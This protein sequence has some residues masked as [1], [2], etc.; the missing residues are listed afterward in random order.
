MALN[1]NNRKL[2]GSGTTQ[3]S[4]TRVVVLAD[5]KFLPRGV[6]IDG[7]NSRDPLNT[8]DVD[9]LQAGL[10]LGKITATKLYR[11]SIIGVT[12]VAYDNTA[13]INTTLTVGTATATE[14]SR[15][16]SSG[17]L[18]ITGPPTA[19]GTVAS[20]TVTYSAVNTSTGV[21]TISALSAAFI[22]G[23]FIGP[24][25][26]AQTPLCLI[27]NGSPVRVTD[28]DSSSIDVELEKAVIG[29]VLDSSQIL[30]WP[31][32]AQLQ[33]WVQDQLQESGLFV[34]DDKYV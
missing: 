14:I 28:A 10:L 31:S 26:G 3:V 27:G 34:F 23:S 7:S 24:S 22:S 16:G 32:N 4:D 1:F 12:T 17:T 33:A 2:P 6:I 8:G 25:D 18:T 21:I 9:Y 15:L 11:P 5:A 19:G 20:A 30:N 13:S 29:G